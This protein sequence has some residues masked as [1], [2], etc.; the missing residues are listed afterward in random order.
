MLHIFLTKIVSI[1]RELDSQ[2]VNANSLFHDSQY[3]NVPKLSSLRIATQDEVLK[4]ISLSP[5]KSSRLDPLPTWLLKENIS[6]L[7]PVITCI[8]NSSLSTGIFPS[9]AHSTIIKPLLKRASLDKNEFKKNYRPVSNIT[10]IGKLVEKISCARLTEHMA[11]HT[12]ADMNQSAYKAYHSTE[13]ALIKVK[14]DLMMSINNRQ[15]VLL[16]LLDL[17]AAFDTI[18]HEILLYVCQPAS[19]S[20]DLHLTG[21]DLT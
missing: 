15:V 16:V 5:N 10:F 19:V 18:D 14:N 17:S 11:K 13:S 21:S 9:G 4:T 20:L 6:T 2:H 12:L 7:L 8:V 3:V 1:R